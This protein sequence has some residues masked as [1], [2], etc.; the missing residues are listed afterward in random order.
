MTLR[1]NRSVI[2][3]I[4]YYIFLLFIESLVIIDNKKM[5]EKNTHLMSLRKAPDAEYLIFITYFP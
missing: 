1:T 4:L 2:I 3:I 5:S